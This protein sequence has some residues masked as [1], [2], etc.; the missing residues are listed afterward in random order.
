MSTETT[1]EAG[2][3][4]YISIGNSDDKLTQ[5]EWSAF[6]A[7]VDTLLGGPLVRLHGRW[8][9]APDVPWQSACWCI[10]F[11]PNRWIVT[12]WGGPDRRL[13][14]HLHIRLAVLAHAYRQDSIAWAQAPITE[15][16]KPLPERSE[17]T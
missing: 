1:Q 17:A 14:E 2:V 8:F 11:D 9:A 7:R 4:A 15:L 6:V 16:I 12:E 3:T 10:E 5:A 13:L